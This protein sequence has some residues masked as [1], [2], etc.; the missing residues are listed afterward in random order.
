MMI[1][2]QNVSYLASF[3]LGILLTLAF[4]PISIFPFVI[5]FGGFYFLL[6]K[7]VDSNLKL[8]LHGVFFGYGYF[9]INL[10]WIPLSIYKVS[11][12]LEWLVPILSIIIPL[13]LALF[14]G[15]F[16]ILTKFGR[17][18]SVI[19]SINFSFL[20]VI[21]EYIRSNAFFPFPWALIGHSATSMLWFSQIVAL[22][23]AYGASLLLGLLTTS[24]FSQ[25]KKYIAFNIV[26]F[27]LICIAGEMRIERNSVDSKDN[28]K[29]R[30]VQPNIQE[31]HFGNKIKQALVFQ[32]LS[33]L[34]LSDGFKEKDYIFWSE[35]A[36]P[37]PIY[38][39]QNWINMVKDFVPHKK[40][41][42]L[43][44][45]ADSVKQ[46]Y[47]TS[48]SFNS[49]LAINE[50]NMILGRY[51]KRILVPF[52]EYVPY[53]NKFAFVGKIA[54][55]VGMDDISKGV[56]SNIIDLGDR[57]KFLPVICS[58]SIVDKGHLKVSSHDSY[59]FILN[60][61]NDSWFGN[62]L[63]P[64]QH[65]NISRIR[66]IE[67][68][69]PVI[70]V[71]NTG[72]SGIIDVFGNVLKV[73]ELNTRTI[74]DASIPAKLKNSTLFYKIHNFVIPA[75]FVLYALFMLHLYAFKQNLQKSRE[76]LPKDK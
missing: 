62:S 72:I 66:A 6:K 55:S 1:I 25:N 8:F 70:R 31:H 29:I 46:G 75:I 39:N 9:F 18:N 17:R 59:R 65:F 13:P 68:G 49:I 16:A 74:V 34:T 7:N 32:E 54:H 56:H 76:V 3:I 28:I 61:T 35:A 48:L 60:I 30:L 20:W 57:I 5:S 47:Y 52:G 71:A 50:E 51:D 21:F 10:Y 23:G 63:G 37:Y 69:L 15:I 14:T 36:F 4:Y 27:F 67:Y 42:A 45:G 43:I 19:F 24:L 38:E 40:N 12:N 64:Y 11:I 26:L 41:T 22:F 44:F 58:E 2:K 33:E 53:K 73:T